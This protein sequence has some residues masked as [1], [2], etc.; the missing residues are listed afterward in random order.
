MGGGEVWRRNRLS[1]ACVCV[2]QGGGGG[3]GKG[4]DASIVAYQH[5]TPYVGRDSPT[6]M[7][8]LSFV[9]VPAMLSNVQL[10][11]PRLRLP[12][13]SPSTTSC[14]DSS[15]SRATISCNTQGLKFVPV[16]WNSVPLA[17]FISALSCCI[18]SN[19]ERHGVIKGPLGLLVKI[20]QR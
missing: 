13:G 2:L 12:A 10:P 8:M 11:S 15:S 16:K 20:L 6:R 3:G 14:M 17:C 5:E 7:C 9:V 18:S 4:D 1:P 19:G